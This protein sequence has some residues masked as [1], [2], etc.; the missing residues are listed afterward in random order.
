[1]SQRSNI[2]SVGLRLAS[3]FLDHII[4]TFMIALACF[5]I[6]LPVLLLL[7]PKLVSEIHILEA[8]FFG[9]LAFTLF[10]LYF[11]KDILNGQSPAKRI[12]KLQIVNKDTEQA[13]G[14]LKCLLRN[15]TIPIWPLEILIILFN[16]S[17]RL[18]DKLANTKVVILDETK[19]KIP[20]N[21]KEIITALLAGVVLLAIIFLLS[22]ILQGVLL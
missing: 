4:M 13:A 8:S 22:L 10:S 3:M 19:E 11:N 9:L 16:P 20:V 17:Q 6:S 7:T 14:P 21:K 2:P 12:V 1:M 15:L 5:I 18:G